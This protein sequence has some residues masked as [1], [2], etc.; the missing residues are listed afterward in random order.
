MKLLL[1]YQEVDTRKII[2]GFLALVLIL[3]LNACSTSSVKSNDS[4]SSH[5]NNTNSENLDEFENLNEPEYPL[6]QN[7]VAKCWFDSGFSDL[8][9]GDCFLH[10]YETVDTGDCTFTY[11]EDGYEYFEITI[12]FR[13][14]CLKSTQYSF[15]D[16]T[17]HNIM[18][19]E[20]YQGFLI[21]HMGFCTTWEIE[22]DLYR[23]YY[24]LTIDGMQYCGTM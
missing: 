8:K 1:G 4:S 13:S 3:G 10:D 11:K 19:G 20:F 23:N 17:N 18:P 2:F 24:D 6:F 21:K 5:S 9:A 7:T 14:Y 16:D 15:S 12:D 22:D